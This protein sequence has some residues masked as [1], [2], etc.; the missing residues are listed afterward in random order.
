MKARS[1]LQQYSICTGFLSHSLGKVVKKSLTHV[2]CG[3]NPRGSLNGNISG[4]RM[5]M[6]RLDC[7]IVAADVLVPR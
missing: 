2:L 5:M 3:E 1:C 7:I 6:L 4:M